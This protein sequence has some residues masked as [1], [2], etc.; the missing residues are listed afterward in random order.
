MPL[1]IQV[2]SISLLFQPQASFSVLRRKQD[3][4]VGADWMIDVRKKRPD[5]AIASNWS[6]EAHTPDFTWWL[7]AQSWPISE[8]ITGK[9]NGIIPRSI[10]NPLG[11]AGRMA[12]AHGF[13][14]KHTTVFGKKP[15]FDRKEM[16]Y[17]WGRQLKCSPE[18]QSLWVRRWPAVILSVLFFFSLLFFSD[19]KRVY[20][21]YAKILSSGN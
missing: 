7:S 9:E 4:A 21:L 20:D 10:R 8:S 16:E 12:Q 13:A 18:Y 5:V 19:H 14:R 15:R 2:V 1:G 17:G 3:T 11:N 6:P